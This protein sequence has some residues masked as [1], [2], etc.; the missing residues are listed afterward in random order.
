MMKPNVER[1]QIR[2]RCIR[3]NPLAG[4]QSRF[5]VQT[6]SRVFG[7]PSCSETRGQRI[8]RRPHFVEVPDTFRVQ[9]GDLKSLAADFRDKPLMVQ[10]MQRVADRLPG[11]AQLFGKIL[12]PD[13]LPRDQR[14]VGNRFEHPVIDLIDQIGCGVERYHCIGILEFGIPNSIANPGPCQMSTATATRLEP[15][16]WFR[17]QENCDIG[18]Q[19]PSR[20]AARQIHTGQFMTLLLDIRYPLWMK[21]EDLRDILQPQLP[22]V[23]I[24]CGPLTGPDPEIDMVAVVRLYPGVA[25]H[26]PN[27]KLVQKLGAGVDGIVRDPDLPAHV[28]VARLRPDAA[29]QEIAEYCVAYV[30]RDQRNLD[31]HADNATKGQ[32]QQ[33]APRRSP[34]TRVGVLGLGHIGARTAKAFSSL[35]FQVLGWSRTAKSIDGVDCRHG[36]DTLADILAQCDYIASVLPSTPRTRNFFDADR[37]ALLKPGA[38]LINVGRGDLIVEEDLVAALD[39]G[40]IGGAV[41]DVFRLEPLPADHAFWAHDRITVTPHVSGWHLDGGLGDVAENYRRLASGQ[42]LLHEVNRTEGY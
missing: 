29:A 35:G 16:G 3:A 17:Q 20:S 12:L 8:Q 38:V 11:H 30:L 33:K 37:L 2:H 40:H 26:L 6:T 34:D 13:P 31:F 41:L 32:W 5:K 4:P 14:I 24:K 21:E 23:T 18:E 28:R 36:D 1:N 22:G 39:A 10:K 27:L 15:R 42:A 19:R 9:V 7:G 25:A